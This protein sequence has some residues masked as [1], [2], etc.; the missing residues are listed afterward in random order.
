MITPKKLLHSKWTSINKTHGWKHFQVIN[1][2]KKKH[3]IELYAIC[4]KSIKIIIDYNE[5]KDV[6]HWVAGWNN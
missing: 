4:N 5:I 3:K 2:Y 1:V 6:N